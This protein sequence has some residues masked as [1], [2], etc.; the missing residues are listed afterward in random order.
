[1]SCDSSRLNPDG[2]DAQIG[3]IPNSTRAQQYVETQGESKQNMEWALIGTLPP[4]AAI[5]VPLY[6]EVEPFNQLRP[7]L[8]YGALADQV[9]AHLLESY[10]NLFYQC[11]FGR[12]CD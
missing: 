12:S 9:V 2:T 10:P 7:V 6:E 1:M 5:D 4:P 8:I 11:M 3:P